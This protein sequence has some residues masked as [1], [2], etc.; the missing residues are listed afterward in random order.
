MSSSPSQTPQG[1]R[2]AI[3]RID[4]AAELASLLAALHFAADRHRLQKRKDSES[5]PYI[6]HPIAVAELLARVAGVND[7]TVL[8]AAVLHDTIED[9]KTTREEIASEFDAE[10]AGIVAEVS[11][12]KSL[13]KEV[14]KKLQIEHAPHLSERAKLVKIADKI[15]NVR[16]V[17]DN[18][19]AKWDLA[20]R[21]EYLDWSE[22]VVNGCRGVNKALEEAFDEALKRG[23]ARLAS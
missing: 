14:R 1:R 12:D 8:Q 20:R 17:T 11:D 23:R 2:I 18:P 4:T 9:T 15:C 3:A 21:I 6:N 13:D 5:S 16:D 7:L 10:V 22:K 19:P